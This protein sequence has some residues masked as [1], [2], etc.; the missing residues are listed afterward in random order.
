MSASSGPIWPVATSEAAEIAAV[1]AFRQSGKADRQ[2]EAS[3]PETRA[4]RGGE[5]EDQGDRPGEHE[6]RLR[7]EGA[8]ICRLVRGWTADRLNGREQAVGD[9]HRAAGHE[10]RC[11]RLQGDFAGG[12]QHDRHLKHGRHGGQHRRGCRG[13]KFCR[14]GFGPTTHGADRRRARDE[15][16]QETCERQSIARAHEAHRHVAGGAHRENKN[17]QDPYGPWVDDLIGPESP[18]RQHRKHDQGRA[19]EDQAVSDLARGQNGAD[20]P[21]QRRAY[22]Q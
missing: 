21:M 9:G 11:G 13:G 7:A 15:A 12:P 10:G 6:R 22:S 5:E 3:L 17:D 18:I 1:W 4:A 2:H 8:F 14:I 19:G 16:R 20:K